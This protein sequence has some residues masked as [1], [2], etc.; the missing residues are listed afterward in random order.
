MVVKLEVTGGSEVLVV[1]G[2]R[3]D[4]GTYV[5]SNCGCCARVSGRVAGS[6]ACCSE[7]GDEVVHAD[8]CGEFDG[9]STG[10][11]GD[12]EIMAS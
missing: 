2:V 10:L 1:G 9:S 5:N 12:I 6:F 3:V 7:V 4:D 11:G 8:C